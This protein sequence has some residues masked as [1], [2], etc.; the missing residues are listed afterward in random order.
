MRHAAASLVILISFQV[1]SAE[2]IPRAQLEATAIR[3]AKRHH[4]PPDL[5]LAVCL[6]ESHWRSNAVGDDGRSIGVC[7]I[8]INTALH[9]Y[10]DGWL[11][12]RSREERRAMMMKILKNPE[13]NINLAA[14]LLRRYLTRFHEDETLAILA[15]NGGPENALI[16]YVNKVRRAR[17]HYLPNPTLQGKRP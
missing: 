8:Q 11:P 7:Q 15:Y 9:L 3:A 5:L 1:I 12:E 10:G 13:Q 16:R 14:R 4:I 6:V 2:P 17:L